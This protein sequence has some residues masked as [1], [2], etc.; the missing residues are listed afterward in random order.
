[1]K[2]IN[3]IEQKIFTRITNLFSNNFYGGIYNLKAKSSS[4]KSSQ[5]KTDQKVFIIDWQM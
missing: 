4:N 5:N 1:M 2:I 3:V